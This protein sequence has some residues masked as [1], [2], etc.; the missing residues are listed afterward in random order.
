MK[1]TEQKAPVAEA[2]APLGSLLV[3]FLCGILV[4]HFVEI[5]DKKMKIDD[6]VGAV[7]VHGLWGTLGTLL[8]GALSVQEGFLSHPGTVG[9]GSFCPI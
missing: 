7:S 6:P 4:V 3:G 1:P 5:L 2:L 9:D 8:V